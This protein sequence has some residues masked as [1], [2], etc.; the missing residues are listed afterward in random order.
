M[1]YQKKKDL[2]LKYE[3]VS[4][5]NRDNT[6]F[7]QKLLTVF[8]NSYDG[9]SHE[10]WRRTNKYKKTVTYS[11]ETDLVVNGLGA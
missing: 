10:E 5:H 4:N 2:Y 1:I 8:K 11:S 7:Q 3:T 9:T 6:Q